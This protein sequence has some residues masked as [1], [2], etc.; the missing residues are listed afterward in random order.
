MKKVYLTFIIL[1]IILSGIF[2]VFKFK[3]Q[4][5]PQES[6]ALGQAIYLKNYY[7]GVNPATTTPTHFKTTTAT[8]SLV[9]D[10]SAADLISININFNSSTTPPTLYWI[11]EFSQNLNDYFWET[12]T[13]IDSSTS[14]THGVGPVINKWVYASTT[15]TVNGAIRKSISIEPIA[16][17]LGRISFWVSGASA[18]LWVNAIVRERR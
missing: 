7:L 15:L 12:G 2:F 6:P 17:R 11:N 13:T 3:K 1:G 16:S 14:V 9:F 4:E 18:D 10:T 8:T 5:S